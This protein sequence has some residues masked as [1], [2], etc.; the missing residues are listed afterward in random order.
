MKALKQ[1][2]DEKGDPQA[3]ALL[4]DIEREQLPQELAQCSEAA[5]NDE[6]AADRADSLRRDLDAKLD[7]VETTLAWPKLVD[8]AEEEIRRT[9]EVVDKHGDADEKRALRVHIDEVHEAIS[10]KDKAI[11]TKR[12][13]ELDTLK[14][15]VLRKRPEFWAGVFL[16]L[17][18]DKARFARFP[19]A[20]SLFAE[21]RRAIVNNQLS[22]LEGICRQLWAL[23]PSTATEDIGLIRG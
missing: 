1:Q 11:L 21:G 3:K 6:D 23:E 15:T 22:G 10:L 17:E 4:A 19:E 12:L 13:D 14:I 9:K 18:D 16:H 5:R 20:Q 7:V 2:A 8:N